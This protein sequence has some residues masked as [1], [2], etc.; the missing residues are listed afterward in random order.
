M[1]QIFVRGASARINPPARLIRSFADPRAEIP[2]RRPRVS[3]TFPATPQ[4]REDGDYC[5]QELLGAPR[6]REPLFW[7]AP[8][9]L[10]ELVGR[11]AEWGRTGLNRD[12]GPV[13][14][15]IDGS[16]PEKVHEER[17][18]NRNAHLARPVA[19]PLNQEPPAD[20][21]L[22]LVDEPA[23]ERLNVLRD[24]PR[25]RGRRRRTP[26][27]PGPAPGGLDNQPGGHPDV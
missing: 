1:P 21:R 23:L 18:G 7:G 3:R 13:G 17:S 9:L 22:N 25:D 16:G 27:A 15:T 11:K 26:T 12:C 19:V 2:G 20:E 8:H 24:G 6:H 4:P 14:R 5:E 10:D